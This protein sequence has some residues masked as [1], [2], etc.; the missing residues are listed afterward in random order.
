[1][2]NKIKAQELKRALEHKHSS[3]YCDKLLNAYDEEKITHNKIMTRKLSKG[4]F[5]DTTALSPTAAAS[6]P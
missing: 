3:V 4:K 6:Q 1:M 2:V 5:R